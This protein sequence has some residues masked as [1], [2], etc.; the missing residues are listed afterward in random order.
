MAGLDYVFHNQPLLQASFQNQMQ[1][2]SSYS[3]TDCANNKQTEMKLTI[4]SLFSILSLL[5]SCNG[6]LSN[7]KIVTNDFK[8]QF[9]KGDTVKELGSNIMVIYQDKKNVYWFGS[10]ETGVYRYDGK[11]LINYT[12]KHGLL[13]N[14]IDEIKEDKPGNI[15]FNNGGELIK[16][17]GQNFIKV[18]TTSNSNNEWKL[19]P[20]DLWFKGNQNS[21]L[22]YRYDGKNLHRL[23]FPET[24]EG[25]DYLTKFPN[26]AYSPYDV[27]LNYKDSE[28]NVWFGTGALGVCCYNGKTFTWLSEKELEFDVETG[29]GIRSLI[30]DSD[31]KFWF[32]NTLYRYNIYEQENTTKY[33]KEKG[34]GSLDGKKDGDLVAIISM[35]KDNNDLWMATYNQGV[36]SYNGQQITHYPVKYNGKDITVYSIYKDNNGNLWLGTHENGAYKFNGK[37]FEKFQPE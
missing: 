30:E 36:Y 28:G 32:S 21:G 14:R 8:E 25:N 33:V 35:E 16:F 1:S 31:G 11:T 10:W 23:K 2:V 9:L 24:K 34:I 26:V 19:E 27:Y 29:F 13:N 7:P 37:T 12:T 17:D 20:D 3:M 5:T 6:Q 22:V 18:S 4:L 15:Y